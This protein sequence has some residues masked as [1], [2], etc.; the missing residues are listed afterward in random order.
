MELLIVII[1]IAISVVLLGIVFRFN[2]QTAKSLQDDKKLE[3]KT[4]KFP[5]NITVAKEMLKI[6]NNEK[7]KI[8]KNESNNTSLYIAVTDKLLI[9]NIKN[10][11]SRIQ[12]I[13][14]ECLHSIQDKRIL[15]F[16]FIFSNI[17]IIY[18][19]IIMVLTITN[20]IQNIEIQLSILLLFTII[21]LAVRGFLETDA[22]IKAEYLSKEYMEN[23]GIL[24]KKELESIMEKY[25]KI[26]KIAVPNTIIQILTSSFTG[27]IVYYIIS[28][29]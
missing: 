13:A 20:T 17:S 15:L 29:I 4:D 3:K 9:A 27:I 12:T 26:S 21:K 19:L 11:Y 25:K 16:N 2:F 18:W 23:K 22:I 28:L 7:V 1:L 24:E 6:L 8:E 14:P 10:N 5:N